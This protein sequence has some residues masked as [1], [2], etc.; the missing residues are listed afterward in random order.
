MF[1]NSISYS[2]YLY[3]SISWENWQIIY[4]NHE[5]DLMLKCKITNF[6]SKMLHFYIKNVTFSFSALIIKAFGQFCQ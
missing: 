2:K 4:E 1:P 5:I 3:Y 6:Y